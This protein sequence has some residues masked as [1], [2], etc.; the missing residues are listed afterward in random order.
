MSVIVTFEVYNLPINL[1]GMKNNVW[2]AFGVGATT[3]RFTSSIKH[4]QLELVALNTLFS[5]I[6]M[7]TEVYDI[8]L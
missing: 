1:Q 5:V 7:H 4:K 6:S 3:V 8:L 2:L